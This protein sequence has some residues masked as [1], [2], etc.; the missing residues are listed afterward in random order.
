MDCVDGATDMDDFIPIKNIMNELYAKDISRKVRSAHNTRGRAGEP[1]SQP[2]YGY[3]KDPQ[4]KKH[5]IID[6]EAAS[7][8]REIFKLY[9]DGNGEDTIARIMQEEQHLNC[10]A[11]WV[12]KGI[13]RGGKKSQ[14]NPYKWKSSTIHGILT[15]QE[16]C[17]D[18]LNFKTRSKSFKNHR[19]IDNPKEDW[20]VFEDRHEAIILRDTYQK[21]QK[22]LKSTHQRAPKEINGPKSI[23]CDIL[24][25]ADAVEAVVE[26]E[27]QRLAEYLVADENRFAEILARRSIKQVES[28]KKTVQS[29]LRKSEMRIEIIPKLLKTLYEDKLSGKT[30]EDNYCVLSQEYSDEREQLQKKILKL[31]RKLTEMGEKENEREE[32]IHAIRKF[33]E[34]RTLTKQVLNELIDHIDVYETQGTGKNKTQRLVIYYKFVGYLDIDP[35][36]CRPNYT[37][38]IREGVAIEYVSCEPSDSLKELFQ[39]GYGACDDSFEEAKPEQA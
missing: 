20:L 9:L 37:A 15:R 26:M 38:D 39:E 3:V 13:N 23:F 16:Y 22:R 24:R 7:V 17:G 1:L 25:R 32:F 29:E 27:L 35:T 5:W 14:P 8:V 12:S 21:V 11:Y 10:T 28:E 30:S 36:Q 4:D 18:V 2:P 34:M 33:M 19:R 31:R 6:P